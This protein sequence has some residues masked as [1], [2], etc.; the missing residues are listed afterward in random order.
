MKKYLDIGNRLKKIRGSL[1]QK[2]FALKAGIP[3]RSYQRYEAGERMPPPDVLPL[4]AQIGN[5]TTDWILEGDIDSL[6]LLLRQKKSELNKKEIEVDELTKELIQALSSKGIPIPDDI[7]IFISTVAFFKE[8]DIDLLQLLE[9]YKKQYREEGISVY[10]DQDEYEWLEKLLTI[11]RNKKE[12]TVIAIQNNI[13]AFL[14]NPDR[15]DLEL[16]EAK[17]K[18][19]ILSGS[20]R[21]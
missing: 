8:C 7:D 12:K 6:R 2:D 11:L 9:N 21:R 3:F 17:D 14:D 15:D 19:K 4:L 13:E 5:T 20:K 10:C 1:S 18:K 16:K